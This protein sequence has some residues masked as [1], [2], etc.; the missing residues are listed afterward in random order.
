LGSALAGTALEEFVSGE[1]LGASH[2]VKVD[3]SRKQKRFYPA[4]ESRPAQLAWAF[5]GNAE[6]PGI[7]DC[8]K[9]RF[10]KRKLDRKYCSEACAKP[11]KRE[12]K[13]RWWSVNR[14][15]I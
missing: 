8:K 2:S 9:P 7:P 11:A 6:P 15:K 10:I 12:A 4:P 3:W 5:V 1:W 13:R 14:G